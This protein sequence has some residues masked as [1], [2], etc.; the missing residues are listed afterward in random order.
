MITTD[1]EYDAGKRVWYRFY[2]NCCESTFT[3]KMLFEGKVVKDPNFK[4]QT[5]TG[6]KQSYKNVQF[7]YYCDNC[8]K[9]CRGELQLTSESPKL[10]KV[11][12]AP[13]TSAS[14]EGGI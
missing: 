4:L 1:W 10:G 7:R 13:T 5:G 2:S 6:T 12:A 9:Q 8:G 3:Q 11:G 14:L